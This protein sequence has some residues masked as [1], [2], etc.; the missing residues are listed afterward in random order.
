[1]NYLG[2]MAILELPKI[3]FLSSRHCESCSIL[4]SYDWAVEQKH[5]DTC[6]VCGNHSVIEKDV[7]E[8]LLRG[9][10]PLILVLA[11]GMQKRWKQNILEAINDDRL[12]II[13]PFE[14]NVKRVNRQTSEK[15]N[16]LIIDLCDEIVIGYMQEG[17]QLEKILRGKKYSSIS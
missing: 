11:R 3:G 15:R 16:K 6:I 5:N 2:N 8:I 14:E 12:L 7:F 13:S 9:S 1:M 17:G 4:K 10:Q